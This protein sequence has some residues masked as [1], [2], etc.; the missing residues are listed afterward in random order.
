MIF[1]EQGLHNPMIASTCLKIAGQYESDV[2]FV[3]W[4]P[5]NFEEKEES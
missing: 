5:D 4:L 3:K 2:V 1:V